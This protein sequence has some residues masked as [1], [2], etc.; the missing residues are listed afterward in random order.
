MK[1]PSLIGIAGAA[2]AGKDTVANHLVANYG[3]IIYKFADPLKQML[4]ERFGWTME[5]WEDREW[6]ERRGVIVT[7]LA[8]NPDHTTLM[9][10]ISP[11]EMAQWLGT[12]VIR[13]H[14]DRDA[15]VTL[16]HR[17]YVESGRHRTVIPDVRFD[18]EAIAI[19]DLGGFVLKVQ[20]ENGD[21]PV[22]PH[23]SEKGVSEF[24]VSAT[25]TAPYPGT[26]FLIKR[27]MQVLTEAP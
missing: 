8:R 21:Q 15:W 19:Q 1:L 4:N 16:M 24:L 13:K 26:E 5:H 2:G 17:A 6:K 7:N 9:P 22:T 10:K 27:A 14:F 11:R 25:V 23:V 18:N 20:R 12:D 3:Y